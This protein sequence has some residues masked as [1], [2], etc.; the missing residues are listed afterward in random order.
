MPMASS[1]HTSL[2]A[3]I[4][5]F[6]RDHDLLAPG[7]PVVVGMSGGVDSMALADVLLRLGYDVTAAHVNYGL[8]G[9]A[10]D[11]DE[12][13]LRTWCAHQQP[14]IPLRV[15]HHD[16]EA[17]AAAEQLSVQEAAREQRYAFMTQ[18][19]DAIGADRVAVG[20]HRG[21]QAET[22]LL[23][24]F[25]GSGVEGLAGMAPRRPLAGH[26]TIELVRP[27]LGASRPAIEAYAEERELPWRTDQSNQAIKYDRNVIRHR[28][29]PVIEAHFE[30]AGGRIAH[31]A[32]LVRA[33]RTHTLEPALAA[34]FARC[35]ASTE[36]GGT[37]DCAALRALPGVW[38][39]RVILEA[40]KRWLPDAPY[41]TA[42]AEEIEPL[43]DAQVG[44]R[45]EAGTGTVWR[46]RGLLRFVAA[47]PPLVEARPVPLGEAVAL[48]QGTI[49]V[50]RVDQPPDSLRAGAPDTVYAD[51][52]ALCGALTVRAW[53]DGDRFQPLGMTHSKKVSDFLTDEQVPPHQRRNVLVME[54]SRRIVWVVGYRLAHPVRI[55]PATQKVVRMRFERMPKTE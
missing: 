21:D 46:E 1:S 25:R 9:A 20:H 13:A 4:E 11:A 45:V 36:T 51:A 8:R 17:K 47:R 26:P 43:I 18:C 35:G 54:D 49:R 39:R 2:L 28:V 22:L 44:R 27:L 23:N 52:Q 41:H 37:L 32:D 53:R 10:S 34:H 40:V 42:F 5:A 3:R 33:Y 30:G 48:S 55:R 16:L 14:A 38:R 6:I 50:D 7:Q 19:A 15:A 29:L 31:A 12:D 24:L